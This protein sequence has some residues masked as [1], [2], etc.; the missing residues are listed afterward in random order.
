MMMPKPV[1]PPPVI[2]PRSLCVNP[3]C[4][5]Q[6]PRIPPR[7][8]NPTPAA[9]MAMKPAHKS[10]Y[11]WGATQLLFPLLIGFVSEVFFFA[12]QSNG[13]C[14]QFH[15]RAPLHRGFVGAKPYA[16]PVG[17]LF[18]VREWIAIF[19]ERHDEFIHK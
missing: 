8:E 18:R 7:M 13:E 5:P 19:H 14:R 11:A 9:K 2:F 15:N 3:N 6:S 10:R 16:G 1:K 17:R 4:V 12:L